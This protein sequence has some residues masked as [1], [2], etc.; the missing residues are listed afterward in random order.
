M[1][2]II[3]GEFETDLVELYQRLSSANGQKHDTVQGEAVIALDRQQFLVPDRSPMPN[4]DSY[5]KLVM[6]DG[7]MRR[8]G[9]TEASRGC[10]HRCRHCPIVP[11][12]NG[13]FLIV[14]PEIVLA[15]IRQQVEAGAQHITF[16]DPDF[17]NGPGHAMPIVQAL[18][19][20]FPE[21][22][23][24]VTIKVEHLLKHDHLLPILRDTGCLFITSAVEA[25][26]DHILAIM[27][28]GHTHADFVQAAT[29]LRQLGLDLNPTFVAFTPWTTPFDYLT[30]LRTIEELDLIEN[31][32][33]IQYAIRLLIPAGSRLLELSDVR[34]LVGSL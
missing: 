12:Y 33:P 18:H 6:G 3:G 23:Y 22:T 34:E 14:Q 19:H 10:K 20:E 24:D 30:M 32:A 21:L 16:G 17:L 8:V 26:S 31:V 28:K 7:R 2:S 15:D 1:Q 29:R 25:T 5:A 9:Y 11:I 4:L 27:E 13:R